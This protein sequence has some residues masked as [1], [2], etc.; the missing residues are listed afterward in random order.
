ML[1]WT[2]NPQQWF[3]FTLDFQAV[4]YIVLHW[5]VSCV[6]VLRLRWAFRPISN[7]PKSYYIES[8]KVVKFH[9][10]SRHLWYA[11]KSYR[12]SHMQFSHWAWRKKIRWVRRRGCGFLEKSV[13]WSQALVSQLSETRRPMSWIWVGRKSWL[14][15]FLM[16][17]KLG[18]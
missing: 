10:C 6:F 13:H 4:R 17:P 18:R 14:W 9:T 11:G 1:A 3:L 7:T 5:C 2:I 12:R 8:P 16:F 15:K